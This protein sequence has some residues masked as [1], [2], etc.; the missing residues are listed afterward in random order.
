VV[1]AVEGLPRMHGALS[2]IL[3]TARRKKA[4]PIFNIYTGFK[5]I[6]SHNSNPFPV[7]IEGED[8]LGGEEDRQENAKKGL[9][10]K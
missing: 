1:Q 5:L 7:I 3:R 10:R 6:Y 9:R 4:T 2:S 8:G